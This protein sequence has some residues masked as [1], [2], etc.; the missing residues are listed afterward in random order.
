MKR[1][2]L[3][4]YLQYTMMR[5]VE[6][7]LKFKKGAMQ[8]LSFNIYIRA[9]SQGKLRYAWGLDWKEKIK[10]MLLFMNID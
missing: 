6:R 1:V 3:Q 7:A 4:V 8:R 2:V 10:K 5:S 9:V